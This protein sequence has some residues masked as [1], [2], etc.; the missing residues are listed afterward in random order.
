MTARKQI[1]PI[2]SQIEPILGN[3]K[4]VTLHLLIILAINNREQDRKVM[5]ITENMVNELKITEQVYFH[6]SS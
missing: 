5:F 1:E 6:E 3:A 4:T 2:C